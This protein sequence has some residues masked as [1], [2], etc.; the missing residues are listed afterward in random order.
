MTRCVTK[1]LATLGVIALVGCSTTN[2]THKGAMI[3][4]G[5]GAA[6]GA[7]IGAIVGHQSGETGEGALIGAGLG[8]L[9]GTAAGAL[10]G[11]AQSNKF[12]PSCGEVY[13]NDLVYCPNDGTQ[14]RQ[15]GQAAP[16]S[17]GQ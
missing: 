12:C 14:L 3:G 4:G 13:T 7:A 11:N 15:Q 10:I 16:Q 1:T 8:A 17:Q 6:A 5:T 9:T 2:P